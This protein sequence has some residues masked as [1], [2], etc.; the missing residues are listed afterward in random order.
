MM[1]GM[2]DTRTSVRWSVGQ[3]RWLELRAAESGA[4]VGAVVKAIVDER[5]VEEAEASA[6]GAPPMT[7][8]EMTAAQ[9]EINAARAAWREV[10]ALSGIGGA[11]SMLSPGDA[12]ALRAGEL[13]VVVEAGS[14]ASSAAAATVPAGAALVPRPGAA[15][16]PVVSVAGM[17]LEIAVGRVLAKLPVGALPPV[18]RMRGRAVVKRGGAAVNGVECREPARLLGPV[19]VVALRSDVRS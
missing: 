3:L 10:A 17:M 13:E 5:M 11:G 15:P 16:A 9:G 4:A 18:W 6:P 7:V 14:L 12:A 19:D 2:S 8:E 1:L